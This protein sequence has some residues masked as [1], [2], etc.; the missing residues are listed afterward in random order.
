MVRGHG[1]SVVFVPWNDYNNEALLDRNPLPTEKEVREALSGNIC[2]CANYH[3]IVT[4]VLLAA[5][6]MRGEHMPENLSVIGT[7]VTQKDGLER[8][9]GK[10]KYFG[11]IFL[12]NMLHLKILRSTYAQAVY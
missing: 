2:R 10:A 1:T 9:T 4:S 6:K 7:S 3:H 12:P 11:D 8:V 5:K